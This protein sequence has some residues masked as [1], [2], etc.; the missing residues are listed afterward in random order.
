MARSFVGG[1]GNIATDERWF[2]I[3]I[4]QWVAGMLSIVSVAAFGQ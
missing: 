3:T 1:F 4:D 2:D